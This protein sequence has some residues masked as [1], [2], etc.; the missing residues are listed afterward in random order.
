VTLVELTEADN[1]RSIDILV[2]AELVIRLQENPGGGYRWEIERSD[3]DVLTVE[4][5]RYTPSSASG[6]GG[7]GERTLRLKAERMGMAHLR[8]E[9]RRPWQEEPARELE[10]HVRVVDG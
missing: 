5:D 2:G 4:D 1:G 8:L 7:G 9:N 10:I 3:D 6:V